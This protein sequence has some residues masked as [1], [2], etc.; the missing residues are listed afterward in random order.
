MTSNKL[1]TI[2]GSFSTAAVNSPAEPFAM[3]T[4]HLVINHPTGSG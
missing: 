4:P 3:L 1:S 2:Y